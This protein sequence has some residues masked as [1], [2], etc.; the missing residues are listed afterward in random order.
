MD[1]LSL[2]KEAKNIQQRKDNLFNKWC[3]EN[4]SATYKRMK[5]EYFLTPYAK[6]NLKWVNDLNGR[7]ETVNLLE[8]N[9]GRTPL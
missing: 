6:I 8:G 7:P 5:L 2:T 9:I 4:C 3:W 1:T